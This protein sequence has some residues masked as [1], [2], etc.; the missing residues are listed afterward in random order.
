VTLRRQLLLVSLLLLSLPWAGCQF[1]REM[2][3]ALRH[4]QEQSLQATAQA[5]AAVLAEPEQLLYPNPQRR[6]SAPDQR[7]SLYAHP[8]R[9][10]L[11]IDGYGDG[12]EDIA[13]V[14]FSSDS[15]TSPLAVTYQG[16]TRNGYL[17]LLLRVQDP[18]VIYHNPGLS[19]E[20]NGDRLLL[21]TW[22]N[23]R[24]Q[25]YVIATAAPGSVQARPAN[26]RQ[27]GLRASRIRGF[28]QDA[29]GG[30]TLELEIPL[31]YT[32]ARLGFYIVN[33]GRRAGGRAETLGNITPLDTAAPPWL[34]YSPQ[35]LQARLA[36]F[37]HQGSHLQVIDKNHWLIADVAANGS[38]QT[39][40]ADTFWLLRVIYRSILSRGTLQPPPTAPAVGRVQAEEINTALAGGVA[41]H[42]YLDPDYS[43]RTILSAAAPIMHKDG[44]SEV[45]T[46]VV[47]ARQSGEEYL[48]LTDQAFNRLLGYSLLALGAGAFGLLGYASLLSWRIGKLSRAARSAIGEDGRVIQSFPRSDAGDEIGELSRHY[49]DLLDQLREYNDYLRTLS[50]KLSHEL[51]TPIAVIQSSLDNL[52]QE[53]SEHKASPVYVARAREGLLR[54]NGILTAMS[55]ANRLEESI[56]N[57]RA[58]QLNLVPLLRE[59]FKAYRGV[60]P[61]HQLALEL[62]ADP[63]RV[64]GVPE[65]IVQALDKLMANAASFCPAGGNIKLRLATGAPG[66]WDISVS[67]EGPGL[68]DELQERLF[69][70]M[71]SLRDAP[72]SI[73]HTAS[74]TALGSA[75]S[76]RESA[77]VHLGL[78]LHIVRLIVDFHRGQ[79][80]AA[81]L[82]D[83]QGV[84]LTMRFPSAP[85]ADGVS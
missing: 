35:A 64:M 36:P 21:R 33:V 63:A 76:E 83:N 41:N 84:C 72:G 78:G 60:Y 28:W 17:Y 45:V 59:V 61:Q 2:E 1:I 24:R 55:E 40:P 15:G 7:T 23:D 50:R 22:H 70:P 38:S 25:D 37:S 30:Y 12:W 82:A 27:Q 48:S 8:F 49:A 51:R 81:N 34:I 10:P 31:D 66:S 57:N 52:E 85:A 32:G 77:G 74:N 29:V 75:T 13:S 53:Q 80:W 47:V 3:G 62:P 44:A 43:T 56:R 5:V 54:L 26:P 14:G 68:P 69:D 58:A 39:R 19:P 71:V 79:A 6:T 16:A 46:G 9:Q 67:N 65:L 11:I 73:A 20:P 18:E 4:G 42:R